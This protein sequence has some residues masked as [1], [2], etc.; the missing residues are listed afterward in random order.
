VKL[1]ADA[2]IAKRKVANYLLAWRPENDKSQF[3]AQAGYTTEHADQLADDIRRQLLSRE[4]EFEESTE[5][6]DT[7]RIV[8]ALIGPNGRA[9]RVVSIWMIET[10]TGTTKFLTLYPA[11]ET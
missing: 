3:L 11:R 8:G 1:P 10:A 7:Y 5:Y 4:A 2:V 6:G 9:L